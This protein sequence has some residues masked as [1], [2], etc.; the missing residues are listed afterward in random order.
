MAPESPAF[1]TYS[2]VKL[3]GSGA[4]PA[5]AVL[6]S[7]SL[8]GGAQAD[9]GDTSTEG[10]EKSV[11]PISIRRLVESLDIRLLGATLGA[12]GILV[13]L[14]GGA[15]VEWAWVQPGLLPPDPVAHLVLLLEAAMPSAQV[16]VLLAQVSEGAETLL[17]R[18]RC[19]SV[20]RGR[21]LSRDSLRG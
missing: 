17:G 1:P 14:A 2:A 6:L 3:L 4:Q 13:P 15:L 9:S 19:W 12:R 10:A 20:E 7:L 8:L 21:D 16:L 11:A 5:L 18:G